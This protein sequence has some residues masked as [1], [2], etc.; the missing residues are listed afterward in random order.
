MKNEILNRYKKG[1]KVAAIAQQL[2]VSGYAVRKCIKQAGLPFR[3]NLGNT[4]YSDEFKKEISDLYKAGWSYSIFE[5]VIIGIKQNLLKS[6]QDC[7]CGF[8]T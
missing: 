8:K 6:R 2:N 3:K 4:K 7:F 1:E 5:L